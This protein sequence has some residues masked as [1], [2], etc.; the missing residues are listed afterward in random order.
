MVSKP[1]TQRSTPSDSGR[2]R[3]ST[4]PVVAIH[5]PSGASPKAR[6]RTAWA[7]LVNR[8]VYE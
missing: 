5:A 4:V 2:M 7:R 1:V 8:L 3:G 6:P